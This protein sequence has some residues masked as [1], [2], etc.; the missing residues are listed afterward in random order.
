[1]RTETLELRIWIASSK[2][3]SLRGEPC[4]EARRAVAA[5][6]R[7]RLGPAPVAAATARVRVL[8]FVQR[9]V[10]LPVRLLL[11]ERRRAVADLDPLD[12]AVVEPT[13]LG[14]VAQVL[15][16]GDRS[17]AERPLLYRAIER[18]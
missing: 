1:M 7:P 6:A 15:V 17:A 11:G 9:E 8:H 5:A 4:L 12:A 2:R 18:L 14:H 3:P 16:A 10:L 13:C